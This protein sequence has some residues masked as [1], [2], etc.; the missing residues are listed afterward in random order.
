[1]EATRA[2]AIRKMQGLD[3]KAAGFMES[4]GWTDAD[5]D[6]KLTDPRTLDRIERDLNQ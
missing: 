4:R 6:W 5:L 1:M 2:A 3:R